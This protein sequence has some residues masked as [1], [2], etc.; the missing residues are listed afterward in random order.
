MDRTICLGILLVFSFYISKGQN[1]TQYSPLEIGDTIPPTLWDLALRVVNDPDGKETISL[2]D[3]KGKVIILDFWGTFCGSCISAMP[4]IHEVQRQ[5]S[6]DMVVIPV[7][8]SD[9]EATEKTLQSHETLRPLSLSSVVEAKLL[10]DVFPHRLVPFYV[11]I[12][13]NGKVAATTSSNDVNQ[14]NIANVLQGKEPNYALMTYIDRDSHLLLKNELL[15][16]SA[17]IS[18]FSLLIRGHIP[19]LPSGSRNRRY[20]DKIV[21]RASSNVTVGML[22]FGIARELLGSPFSEKQIEF[23]AD[24]SM[25][26]EIDIRNRQRVQTDSSNFLTYEFSVNL[27]DA[28]SL[29]QYML[30]DLN[31]CSGFK[32]AIEKRK[33]KCYV[34]QSEN[35]SI[36]A[37]MQTGLS[38]DGRITLLK[39]QS[40]RLL[41]RILE[42]EAVLNGKIVVD[43]TGIDSRATISVRH[44]ETLG[45]LQ[46]ELRKNGLL[47]FEAEREIDFFVISK[48]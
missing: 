27:E 11:W 33:V 21:G 34:L 44:F 14:D 23:A 31:Q 32:G 43:E 28:D 18:K 6:D 4:K 5:F 45:A 42:N 48:S 39:D 47:L 2:G 35:S 16:A 29:Y 3:Y 19:S 8:W 15:P 38:Q 36:S 12:D 41:S 22:Y 24:T 13:P 25:Y 40:L 17:R 20:G 30:T 37:P 46:S 7:S 26:P 1:G 10:I 9:A